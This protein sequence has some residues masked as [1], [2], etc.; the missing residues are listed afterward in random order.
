MAV[1][2]IVWGSTYF[3]IAVA[4]QTIP[5]SLMAAIRFL[6]AGLILIGIDIVRHPESRRLPTRRQL[7]DSI[8][9]G[10]CC[11]ASGTGSWS[12]RSRSA[13]RP[14]SPRCLSR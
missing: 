6:I 11:S 1:V 5:G 8:I 4:I 3:G 14:G 7:L 12:S 2:Y 10:D 9:V 13:C